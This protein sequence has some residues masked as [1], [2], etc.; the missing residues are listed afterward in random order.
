M[1][2]LLFLDF[3]LSN[4]I[5]FCPVMQMSVE[6]KL[7]TWLRSPLEDYIFEEKRTIL[8]EHCKGLHVE[9][10]H[11]RVELYCRCVF[12]LADDR[13]GLAHLYTVC[14]DRDDW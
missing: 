12:T 4:L 3:N 7:A 8:C 1:Q 6:L 14:S 2:N 10:T 13:I 5:L 11:P 9:L